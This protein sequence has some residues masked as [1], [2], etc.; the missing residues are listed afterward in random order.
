VWNDNGNQY[1]YV[2]ITTDQRDTKS[3]LIRNQ[4]PVVSI[5][6]KSHVLR[7]SGPGEIHMRQFYCNF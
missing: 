1:E 5:Q 6:L 4:H 3:N 7:N 2:C